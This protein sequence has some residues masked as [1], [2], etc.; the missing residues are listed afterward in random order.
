MP[1]KGPARFL[2]VL[3][4]VARTTPQGT[5]RDCALYLHYRYIMCGTELRLHGKKEEERLK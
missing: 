1:F 4:L 2:T 3:T 5:H